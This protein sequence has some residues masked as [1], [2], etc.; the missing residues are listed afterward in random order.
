MAG[1]TLA[2]GV[3]APA[4]AEDDLGS[5]HGVNYL[6]ESGDDLVPVDLACADGSHPTGGGFLQPSIVGEPFWSF[7]LGDSW[8]VFMHVP[9]AGA[10]T[11]N[12]YVMCKKGNLRHREK[13]LEI[14][15]GKT[16]LAKVGCPGATHATGGGG[17][18]E[19]SGGDGWINSS[20]PYDDGDRGRKP[21]DGWKIRI[22]NQDGD[23]HPMEVH[24]I[25]QKRLPRYVQ[26]SLMLS[27]STSSASIP[28]CRSSDPVIGA[29]I[30]MSGE[31]SSGIPRALEPIDKG[32]GNDVPDD[33]VLANGS[34]APGA[35]KAKKLT[36]YAICDT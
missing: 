3:P 21:D 11:V 29:G 25:C 4:H 26:D 1:L 14:A 36:G 32:D 22:Y 5:S 24:A 10:Q 13:D 31:A 19:A 12:A 30:R 8:R 18:M 6:L 17:A 7:P 20:Y 15:A 34:N 28:E 23:S 9:A 2:L 27:P 35:P 33:G 16:K